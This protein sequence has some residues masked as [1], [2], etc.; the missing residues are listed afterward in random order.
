MIDKLRSLGAGLS[1]LPRRPTALV[2]QDPFGTSSIAAGNQAWERGRYGR[3]VKLYWAALKVSERRALPDLWRAAAYANLALAYSRLGK[4]V[5]AESL[6]RAVLA[7]YEKGLPLEHPRVVGCLSNLGA[8]LYRQGQSVEAESLYRRVL[9]MNEKTLGAAHP[10][11]AAD[12]SNLGTI[13]SRQGRYSE[14][15][16]LLRRAL[17]IQEQAL[18]SDHPD[19]AT[20]LNNLAFIYESQGRS[21][22]AESLYRRALAIT[23][24][25]RGA[26]HP[27]VALYLNNLAYLCQEQGKVEEAESLYRR[28]LAIRRKAL[29]TDH[30]DVA[31]TL[32]NYASLLSVTLRDEKSE[33]M[34]AQ[35]Q[36]IR[37]RHSKN[38]L[39]SRWSGPSVAPSPE[40]DESPPWVSW[41]SATLATPVS[42]PASPEWA[43]ARPSSPPPAREFDVDRSAPA[44]TAMSLEAELQRALERHELQIYYQPV[45]SL[46]SGQITGAEALLRWEHPRRG[47]LSPVDFVPVADETGL[48]FTIGEELLRAAC[49][50]HQSWS[51]AG[52]P[53]LR[54]LINL[55]K[56]QLQDHALPERIQKM[57]ASTGMTPSALQLEIAESDALKEVEVS[58]RALT[59]LNSTGVRVAI[60]DAGV[61]PSLLDHLQ[62]LPIHALKLGK[63]LVRRI[64]TDSDGAAAIIAIIAQAHERELTVIALGVETEE[65]LTFL[66]SH[67]CDEIQGYLFRRAIPAEAF[68]TL[69]QEGQCL[70]LGT[71]AIAGDPLPPPPPRK[72]GRSD[73]RP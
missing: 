56:R 6:Y 52:H 31:T 8:L 17:S 23:E 30:P 43:P 13:C 27:D 45:V 22:E 55:S 15:E 41:L 49:T 42:A 59:A 58:I 53:D 16:P 67:Q 29:G 25:A 14:A 3:A 44:P 35:A 28:A 38:A 36:A 21:T 40:R 70:P 57:L 7:L 2:P 10:E 68:T 71:T 33:R 26:A 63:A 64:T 54:L 5:E 1:L 9:A 39:C 65:Q 11:V 50:Q 19:I 61:D 32:E 69:L 4:Y 34:L 51:A 66:R 37:A 62:R 24:R 18:A 47:L 73:R 72:N 12:L 20:S 60:D 46:V 48:I